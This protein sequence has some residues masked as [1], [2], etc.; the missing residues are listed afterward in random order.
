M[1]ITH[2][3]SDETLAA[4]VNATLCEGNSL[5]VATHL[6]H[7]PSCRKA[8]REMS[9]VGGGL[10]DNAEAAPLADDARER[11]L[12]KLDE[13]SPEASDA[14]PPLPEGERPMSLV[15]LYGNG[16][17]Q[18]VGPGVYRQFLDVPSLEGTRVFML[19]AAPGTRL[20]DHRH[21]GTEWTCV[22]K[23]A[24]IHDHGRFGAGDFDEADDSVAHNPYVED[25]EECICLVALNGEVEMTGWLGRLIQP[26]LRL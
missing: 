14:K 23:G 6:A 12:A 9:E 16:K 19:K 2:H 26:L 17:W 7:C 21:A 1:K 5:V 24:F 8:V 18:W 25:G 3:P 11:C 15:S 13:M 4:F 10:L 20:P 22:L